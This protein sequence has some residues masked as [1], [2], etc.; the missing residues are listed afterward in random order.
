V[1]VLRLFISVVY[2]SDLLV[3]SPVVFSLPARPVEDVSVMNCYVTVGYL[4]N[5]NFV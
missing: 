5:L 2:G 4:L 3:A 1:F